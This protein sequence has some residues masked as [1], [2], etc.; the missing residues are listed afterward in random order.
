V[1]RQPR[2]RVI[3]LRHLGR[4]RVIGCWQVDDVLIDPGPSSCLEVLLGALGA[5]RP[6]AVLLTHIHL[7][8][9]GATG[10]LVRRWPDLK[11]YVH[12]RGAP[13]LVDPSRLLE[14]AR[15]LYGADM[16]RLWGEVLAVPEENVG[17]LRG[18]EELLDGRFEVA[19]TP[20]HASHHVSYLYD[21]IAFVGDVGGVRIMPETLAI[22]PT[23]PPDID[24]EAW[25]DSIERVRA[26]QPEQLAM[27][28]F[29]ASDDVEGQL[30]E[31]SERLDTWTALARTED[32][33]TFIGVVE[34]EIERGAS[35]ASHSSYIQAAPPEQLYAGLERYWEKRDP[36]AGGSG[37]T[38]ESTSENDTMAD[39]SRGQASTH[40]GQSAHPRRSEHWLR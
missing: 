30:A 32:I 1:L 7:D 21:R 33:D 40:A 2:L 11:V 12:E 39:P 16:D 18:G 27:T 28:H 15:R 22:P 26:W 25:H 23:P 20:G 10:L 5:E 31:L 6:S 37:S 19:Y 38:D 13:H 3:D 8:H 24:V 36:L 9:A 17:I 34:S 29:G 4:E 35:P 14:S